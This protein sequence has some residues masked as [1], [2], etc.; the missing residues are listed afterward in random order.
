MRQAAARADARLGPLSEP[1]AAARLTADGPSGLIVLVS[2]A[3]I[4]RQRRKILPS[5]LTVHV[6]L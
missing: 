2:E 3:I 5:A 4:R 1:I 6:C